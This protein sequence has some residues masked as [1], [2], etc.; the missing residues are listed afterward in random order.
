MKANRL[1]R[2]DF[3]RTSAIVTAAP[4]IL[5]SHIWSAE[6][7]PNDRLTLGCI[8][9]GTQGVSLMDGFVSKKETQVVAVCDV[10][11][12]RREARRKRVEEL[13]AKQ[14]GR[15]YK[16]CDSYNDF[17]ELLARKDIDAV[18]IA[19]PDH[20]HA[21]IAIAACKADKDIYC[22][23]PLTESIHEA[24]AL[25]DA[26]RKNK[27]VFQTGSMQRSSK[28]FRVACELVRNGVVGQIK[29][30]EVAVGGP[31]V[32]CNLPEEAMEP[33][34]DW[35]MWLGPAPQRP[36]HSELSPRG[37]HKH[38]PNWRKYREYGGGMVTDWG[39]H[40]FDI[41]QWG[42]GMD[43]S[44]PVEVF[45]ASNP[46]ATQGV[47]LKYAN[48]VE[49]VH[50]NGGFGITFIGTQGKVL[51]NRGKFELW[52]GEDAKAATTDSAS[53]AEKE[54]LANAKV[55]LYQS[56]EHKTDWITAIKNRSKPICDVEIGAR[57]VTVCHL[58][59]LAYY[60]GQNFK[61]NPAKNQFADGT[62]NKEWL[63]VPHRG[64]WKV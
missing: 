18:V 63:D 17:R 41:A 8:G 43:E 3:I 39:A 6:T 48:G 36:Y 29:T 40:H 38:F 46:K 54:H 16:G 56:S 32:P 49:M 57:S 23:K 35:D 10:D 55:K 9:M 33:G 2:R 34:L 12:T 7:K 53:L 28:E 61:W 37:L 62:G 19:T 26:V 59:N 21:A 25:V 51:V 42:L 47:R 44:G 4:F 15:D 14:T 1:T 45:A 13:Y 27:R 22:E 20:W 50:K 5:P 60:H 64:P 30:V 24:R 58:V 11:T 52:M 31:G